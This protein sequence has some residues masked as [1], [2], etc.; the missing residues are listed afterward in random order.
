L[1]TVRHGICHPANQ[2]INPVLSYIAA[3]RLAAG[4]V[5]RSYVARTLGTRE[6]AQRLYSSASHS[7]FHTISQRW[8]LGSWK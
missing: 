7:G 6:V 3:M 5:F 2:D 1:F 8:L 4:L